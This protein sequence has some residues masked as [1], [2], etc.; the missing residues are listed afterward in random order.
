MS[1][2]EQT[3]VKIV[4]SDWLEQVG[5]KDQYPNNEVLALENA[6]ESGL[7][8]YHGVGDKRDFIKLAEAAERQEIRLPGALGDTVEAAGSVTA[9]IIRI[10]TDI[11]KLDK[12]PYSKE[13]A[14]ELASHIRQ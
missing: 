1:K 2:E 10:Y 5:K 6:I 14:K 4:L 13:Q 3:V 12:I 8:S 9:A 11:K 7:K